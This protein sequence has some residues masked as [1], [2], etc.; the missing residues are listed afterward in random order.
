M[1][2]KEKRTWTNENYF[3]NPFE[4]IWFKSVFDLEN[5]GFKNCGFNKICSY[6]YDRGHECM[7]YI[8]ENQFVVKMYINLK[9]GIW[10]T[11]F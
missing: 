6:I 3:Y 2:K 8:I 7:I 11:K 5:Y 9:W 4:H 1:I 10:N